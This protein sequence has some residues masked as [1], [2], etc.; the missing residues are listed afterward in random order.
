LHDLTGL[1]H[2]EAINLKIFV[3]NNDG[4]GIFSTLSQRGVDGFEEV[5]GTPHGLDPAAIATSMGIA[6][7]TIDSQSQL[8]TELSE[9]VKG[10]SVVVVNVPNRDANADFLKGIYNSVSSM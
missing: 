6:A 9:P 4:G 5:F 10:M 8:I 3:I 2:K 7:K 1:I